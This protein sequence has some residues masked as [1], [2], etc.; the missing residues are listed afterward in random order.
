MIE[1]DD[2][3]TQR[4]KREGKLTHTIISRPK[5][6]EG[7][8]WLRGGCIS[9]CLQWLQ[10]EHEGFQCMAYVIPCPFKLEKICRPV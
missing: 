5:L 9:E 1:D 3:S 2:E 8:S 7:G 4:L 6:K 10:K